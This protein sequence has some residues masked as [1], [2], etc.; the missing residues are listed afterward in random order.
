[1]AHSL[2][3]LHCNTRLGEAHPTQ[4]ML[5]KS[6]TELS[7]LFGGGIYDSNPWSKSITIARKGRQAVATQPAEV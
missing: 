3:T 5:I 1:M 2:Q 6:P 7:A 4:D